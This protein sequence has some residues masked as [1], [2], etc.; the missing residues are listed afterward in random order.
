VVRRSPRLILLLTAGAYTV[1]LSDFLHQLPSRYTVPQPRGAFDPIPLSGALDTQLLVYLGFCFCSAQL[2]QHRIP[3]HPLLIAGAAAVLLGTLR[4]GAFHV[5]GQ[6]AFAYL[7]L[8][9]A[10]T[11]PSWSH[12]IGREHDYIYAFPT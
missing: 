9:A 10:C 12:R 8:C 7:L 11:L 5:L 4:F 3:V 2:Y 1:V 6:P